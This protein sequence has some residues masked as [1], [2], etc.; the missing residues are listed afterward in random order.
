MKDDPHFALGLNSFVQGR[1][2]DHGMITEADVEALW[3]MLMAESRE[4]KAKTQP[5]KAPG[6]GPKG[7]QKGQDGKGGKGQ[8]D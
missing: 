1:G 5:P 8:A 6:P 4:S 3:K 7:G 2:C